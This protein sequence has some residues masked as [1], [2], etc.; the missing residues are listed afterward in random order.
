MINAVTERT[1]LPASAVD[2][3]VTDAGNTPDSSWYMSLNQGPA[4]AR[5]WVAGHDGT[6]LRHPGQLSTAQQAADAKR[7]RDLKA[8]Q[9]RIERNFKCLATAFTP[10]A[11]NRCN[12]KFPT[13]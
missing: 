6:D 2:Y 10:A 3:L 1:H 9:L 12:R 11:V 5:S 4:T 13:S 7:R 8:Q